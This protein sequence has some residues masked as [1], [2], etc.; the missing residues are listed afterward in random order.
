MID[1]FLSSARSLWIVLGIHFVIWM[2]VSLL[3]DVH[4]DMADHWVWSRFLQWGY[5]EHPPLVALNIRIWSMIV[6]SSVLAL[7]FGSV[8][9]SVIILL[10]CYRV[11]LLFFDRRTAL[12]F[13]LILE[14][15]PYFTMGSVFWHI[16]QP[17]MLCWLGCMYTIGRY[18]RSGN[19]NW[20]FLFGI[21]AG[22]GA[23]AKYTIVLMPVCLAVWFIINKET[24]KLL[25]DWRLYLSALIAIAIISPN[26]YWNAQNDWRTFTFVFEKGLT[27]SKYGENFI[28]FFF[29]QFLLFSLVY[30]I[31]FW[32]VVVRRQVVT[33]NLWPDGSGNQQ[34]HTFLLITGILPVA[35]FAIT[36]FR[37]SLTDPHWVNVAYFSAFM[38]LARLIALNI[39]EGK[40]RKQT[41]IFASAFLLNTVLVVFTLSHILFRI[42]PISEPGVISLKKLVGWAETARKIE[43]MVESRIGK[44]PPFVVSR[45]Y[46]T[47]SALAL[48]L[49]NQPMPHSIEKEVRNVWSPESE[50][51]KKGAVLVCPPHECQRTLAKS[52]GRFQSRFKKLGTIDTSRHGVVFRRLDVYLLP[53]SESK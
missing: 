38:L 4:P 46:Q 43:E 36:S 15:T 1:R 2:G 29:S 42:S 44:M 48:Y 51:D 12:I 50:L 49:K 21:I 10:V 13:V 23:Q 37:G 27:G 28:Q 16:D 19:S 35:T 24:R 25:M 31:Y 9:Y 47:A 6:G 18:V 53:A 41:W 8:L 30:S 3:L 11:G 26:L 5:Y 17:Y 34:A 39:T 45:E 14:T 7:K 52:Q 22:L 32:K 40:V 20:F 33:A